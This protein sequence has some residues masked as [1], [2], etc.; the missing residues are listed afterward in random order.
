[1]NMRRVFGFVIATV[2]V[3]GSTARANDILVN[4]SNEWVIPSG[5]IPLWIEV[6]GTT[7]TQ[8]AN[9]PEPQHGAFYFFAG[10][11]TGNSELRQ[12]ID[13]S[14]AADSIDAGAQSIL[15]T[16]WFRS[17]NQN[18]RD[19][20]FAILE[21][22]NHDFTSLLWT[23]STDKF[24]QI[25]AWLPDTLGGIV[26]VDT[27]WVRLRLRSKRGS[28]TNND[29]YTDNLALTAE[30]PIYIPPKELV[31]LPDTLDALLFWRGSYDLYDIY[32]DTLESGAFETLEG[33]TSDEMFIDSMGIDRYL[34]F[35]K[36]IGRNI[37]D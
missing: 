36:V 3:F 32:S 15:L 14:I 37:A 13:V 2:I 9:N 5:D 11:S 25:D 29:G 35:Y 20:A 27:R 31:I 10:G 12:D 19:T 1:M 22:W 8:R 4:S 34:K 17:Y 21:F 16:G 18:P 23:D 26:P 33:T 24:Y 6:L 7:W 30:P 28:G